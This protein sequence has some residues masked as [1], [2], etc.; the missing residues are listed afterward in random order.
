MQSDATGNA[1]F[2]YFNPGS[3][4]WKY[5]GHGFIHEEYFKHPHW[6]YGRRDAILKW[7]D[8]HWPGITANKPQHG[9]HVVIVMDEDIGFGWPQMLL[10]EEV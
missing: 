10:G 5:E 6:D 8:G 4:K 3:G 9:F 1:M 2:Y 7:N